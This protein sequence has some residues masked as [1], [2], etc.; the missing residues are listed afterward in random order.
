MGSTNQVATELDI[1]ESI[2][3]NFEVNRPLKSPV[4]W[5]LGRI[6]S[7]GWISLTVGDFQHSECRISFNMC[8]KYALVQHTFWHTFIWNFG[9]WNCL[10]TL[11]QKSCSACSCEWHSNE[12]HY[13]FWGLENCAA[14][15]SN[16]GRCQAYLSKR[17]CISICEQTDKDMGCYEGFWMVFAIVLCCIIGLCLAYYL[18]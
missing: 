7:D 6:K 13:F 10:P 8:R 14:K 4:Q 2:F 18:L 3:P 5:Q 11:V 9:V 1:S 16:A 12:T 15:N 17:D